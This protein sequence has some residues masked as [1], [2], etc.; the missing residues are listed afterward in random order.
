MSKSKMKVL[1]LLEITIR[2]GDSIYT[3]RRHPAGQ[4]S[5]KR[6]LDLMTDKSAELEKQFQEEIVQTIPE[7]LNG[8]DLIT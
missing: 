1:G 5:W 6:G 2:I 3:R 8:T 4:I 7:Y